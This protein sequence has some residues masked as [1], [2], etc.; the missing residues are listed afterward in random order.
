MSDAS[1]KTGTGAKKT[2]TRK[3]PVTKKEQIATE[4]IEELEPQA[5]EEG[6]QEKKAKKAAPRKTKTKKAAEEL[7]VQAIED[8]KNEIEVA[9]ASRDENLLVEDEFAEGE[10]VQSHRGLLRVQ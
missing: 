2:S 5:V 7:D 8:S 4:V 3:K 10:A 9:F 6:A 1:E